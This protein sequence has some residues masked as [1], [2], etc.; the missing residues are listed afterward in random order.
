MSRPG[1]G[2]RGVLR[3]I[4]RRGTW[5]SLQTYFPIYS[6]STL[7]SSF[8][9]I[10]AI[11]AAAL[12]QEIFFDRLRQIGKSGNATALSFFTTFSIF[13]LAFTVLTIHIDV[14]YYFIQN[15]FSGNNHFLKKNLLTCYSVICYYNSN[16]HNS[17]VFYEPI[18]IY[19]ITSKLKNRI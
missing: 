5:G 1:R 18:N 14:H 7:P 4:H 16:I 17:R 6:Y 12:T 10:Y 3:R 8:A 19:P 9:Q 13:I 2:R 11:F 15:D